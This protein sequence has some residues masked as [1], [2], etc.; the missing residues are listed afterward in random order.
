MRV[1]VDTTIWSLALRRKSEDLNKVERSFVQELRDL[2]RQGRVS[3]PGIVR[4]EVLSGIRNPAQFGKIR[5]FL[6]PFPDELLEIEDYEMAATA[7]NRCRSQGIAISAVDALICAI[8]L[9]KDL[10]IFT[11]DFDFKMYSR[12]LPLKLHVVHTA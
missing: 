10:S 6:R 9:R 4:Q 8:A 12:V 3:L 7:N 11:T 1:L 2:V 5:D